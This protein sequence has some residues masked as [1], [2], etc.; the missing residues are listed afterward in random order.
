MMIWLMKCRDP[1]DC[2]TRSSSRPVV[3]VTR[4]SLRATRML[5]WEPRSATWKRKLRWSRFRE[6][7]CGER[8]KETRNSMIWRLEKLATRV[9]S[10][11]VLR[12]TC[13]EPNRE[14]RILKDLLMLAATTLEASRLLSK[15]LK[16]S[17]LVSAITTTNLSLTMVQFQETANASNLI[18]L[19]LV[20][21]LSLLKAAMPICLFSFVTLNSDLRNARKLSTLA[22]VKLKI[23]G[24]F[25]LKIEPAT[26]IFLLRKRPLRNT[27]MFCSARTMT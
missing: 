20:K 23:R 1:K 26:V 13:R 8:S 22:V 14:L 17:L 18:T 10:S 12:W 4:T 6:L 16:L 7:R 5:T 11:R 15:T 27:L 21:Q 24:A 2:W 25:N 9:T 3:F 19:K